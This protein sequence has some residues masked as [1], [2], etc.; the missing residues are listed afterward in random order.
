MSNGDHAG[1]ATQE[2]ADRLEVDQTL[3]G[4]Q[5]RDAGSNA[6]AAWISGSDRRATNWAARIS[7]AALRSISSTAQTS[8][9]IARAPGKRT[10][11]AKI[12][13]RQ[14]DG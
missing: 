4:G 6:A 12:T 11:G 14:D 5:S 10:D 7:C 3:A 9:H 1:A 2:L 8:R 13:G